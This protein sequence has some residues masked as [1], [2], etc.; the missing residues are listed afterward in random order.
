MDTRL[1]ALASHIQMWRESGI[2]DYWMHVGYMGG[3]LH[4]FGDHDIAVKEGQLWRRWE[5]SWRQVL[6]GKDFWLFSVA[7][8]F[9]WARDLIGNEAIDEDA[10]T[11]L[12]DEEAGYIKLIR[13]ATGHRDVANFT[14][15]VKRFGRGVH[16]DLMGDNDAT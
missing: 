3:E 7:G 6:P 5:G 2:I 14:F 9:A 13:V 15:E 1:A 11:I 10:L 8:A 4:R 16:P 12:F